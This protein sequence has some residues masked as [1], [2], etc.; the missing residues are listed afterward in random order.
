MGE[1]RNFKFGV[2]IDPG[3]KVIEGRLRERKPLEDQEQC[4]WMQ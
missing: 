4:Y 2:L 1:A 3:K